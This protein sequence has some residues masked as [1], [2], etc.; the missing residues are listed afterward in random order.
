MEPGDVVAVE[1]EGL[2]RV[3]N[4]VVDWDIDLTGAGERPA[5]SAQ[6]LHVALA[7]PEDEAER[8]T[9]ESHA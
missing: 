1:I 3:E 5:T 9:E 7:I 2:G 6:T 4:T 8:M